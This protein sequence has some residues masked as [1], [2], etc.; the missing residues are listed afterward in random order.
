MYI[1]IYIERERGERERERER[2]S[3]FEQLR[4][5]CAP[6]NQEQIRPLDQIPLL[7]G[8]TW[9]LTFYM[10]GSFAFFLYFRV[11]CSSRC[12]LLCCFALSANFSI[13]PCLE[14]PRLGKPDLQ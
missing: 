12:T 4:G 14:R 11:T 1:Y 2:K 13:H 10:E 9:L 8:L 5:K 7:N 3:P 6:R